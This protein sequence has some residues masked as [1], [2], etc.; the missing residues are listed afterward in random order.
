MKSWSNSSRRLISA[1]LLTAG[2]VLVIFAF[3]ANESAA[4][5]KIGYVFDVSG[6]WILDGGRTLKKT[7]S[8]PPGSVI[9]LSPQAGVGSHYI[10]I[11]SRL[12]K[13]L[14]SRR[15]TSP[16]NCA[17]ITLP[18]TLREHS[19]LIGRLFSAILEVWSLDREKHEAAISRS[20]GG[21]L[22]EAVL[23]LTPSGLN[24]KPVFREKP[25]G[26]YLLRFHSKAGDETRSLEPI[27]FDWDPKKPVELRLNGIS[28]G[29]YEIELLD[30]VNKEP[31][32]PGEDAWV[33]IL[34]A[35]SSSEKIISDFNNLVSEAE[36]WD[37]QT[38]I[39]TRSFL[40]ASLSYFAARSNVTRE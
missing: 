10:Y 19:S 22:R 27:K 35:S 9:R 26:S 12:G 29:L 16:Q 15:C 38:S 37:K 20:G 28:A 2:L 6:E 36:T 24:L 40:R 17:S 33:L 7:D 4:Q 30:P 11:H 18:K 8:V 25:R 32:G 14:E 3:P 5:D 21:Q 34:T 31:L 23:K 39:A 13:P 1:H